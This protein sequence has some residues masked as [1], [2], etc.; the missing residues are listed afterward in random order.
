MTKSRALSAPTMAALL[1]TA[2]AE[3][4]A[5]A[6]GVADKATAFVWRQA[7]ECR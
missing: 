5:R 2:S 4:L 6:Q 7:C 1:A 3:S